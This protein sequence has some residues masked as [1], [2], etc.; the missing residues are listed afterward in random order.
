[1]AHASVL[2]PLSVRL[3]WNTCCDR[4]Q[5]LLCCSLTRYVCDVTD[6]GT[7][8]FMSLAMTRDE[9]ESFLADLHI[10]VVAIDDPDPDRAPLVAP[11]W[12]SYEPGGN[13]RFVTARVS[14]KT[15]LIERIGRLTILVQTES[16]PYKYVAVEGSA[17]VVGQADE[18]ER[19]ALAHRYLG[20]EIG[21][22]YMVVTADADDVV[23][24][25]V[26]EIWRTTD[27]SKM[28]T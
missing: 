27:F 20:E 23:V 16:P 13:V 6:N 5:P 26:P 18:T 8:R 7:E 1:M 10:G 2:V 4:H 22:A 21:D 19:R 17:A 25:V 3:T 28:L 15:D 11:V 24:E 14:V 9:R 12:I